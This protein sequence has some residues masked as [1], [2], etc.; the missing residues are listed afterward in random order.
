MNTSKSLYRLHAVAIVATM[1]FGVSECGQSSTKHSNARHQFPAPSQKELI[2]S[3]IVSKA[4]QHGID[5]VLFKAILTQESQ[6]KVGAV[7]RRTQDYG[8]GQINIRNI[9]SLKLNKHRLLTDAHYSVEQSAKILSYFHT[10]Y[11]ASGASWF[12]RYNVGNRT[13][14]MGM[15][16]RCRTYV[17]AVERYLPAARA[18]AKGGI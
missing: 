3:L 13:M 15:K 2:N 18:V 1:L 8:I 17:A 16:R 4:T 6:L 11:S 10:R 7:N 12:C 14:T 9:H 5:P